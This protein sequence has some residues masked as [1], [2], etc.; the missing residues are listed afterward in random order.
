MGYVWSDDK[1]IYLIYSYLIQK[2]FTTNQSTKKFE[3]ALQVL[4][5]TKYGKKYEE[6]DVYGIMRK[7][8]DIIFETEFDWQRQNIVDVASD[9]TLPELG[10]DCYLKAIEHMMNMKQRNQEELPPYFGESYTL[11][12]NQIEELNQMLRNLEPEQPKIKKISE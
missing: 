12:Q 11:Y 10:S 5:N 1:Y 2:L 9:E 4:N 6:A 3:A 8:I 7:V